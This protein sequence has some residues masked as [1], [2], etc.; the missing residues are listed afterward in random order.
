MLTP[1]EVV[2]ATTPIESIQISLSDGL[3]FYKP[4]IDLIAHLNGS[5]DVDM[6]LPF[7]Y[8]GQDSTAYIEIQHGLETTP[9]VIPKLGVVV[10]FIYY[11]QGAGRHYMWGSYRDSF[12]VEPENPANSFDYS[13]NLTD[14][15]E[16][17]YSFLS[18]QVEN[19]TIDRVGYLG[20]IFF[21]HR[22]V[23]ALTPTSNG[24]YVTLP[25]TLEGK[26]LGLRLA[27]GIPANSTWMEKTWQDEV[28]T[29][30]D[31]AWTVSEEMSIDAN[32]SIISDLYARWEI[33]SEPIYW[34]T[35]EGRYWFGV[36]TGVTST[37]IGAAIVTSMNY[38]RRNRARINHSCRRVWTFSKELWHRLYEW[39]KSRK[40]TEE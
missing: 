16:K 28:I 3:L 7:E 26:M 27:L 39:R 24:H 14:Q 1:T 34:D 25:F 2:G 32:E 13:I 35:L 8:A 33:P 15:Q 31:D 19:L 22:F 12:L 38:V 36:A 11:Q 10:D 5:L 37:L 30:Y 20:T 18:P 4:S 21:E 17:V 29:H 40:A 23:D 6:T 9:T